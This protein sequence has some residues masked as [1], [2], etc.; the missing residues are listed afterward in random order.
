MKVLNIKSH[1][2]PSMGSCPDTCGQTDREVTKPVG[3]FCIIG[4]GV[5]GWFCQWLWIILVL[6]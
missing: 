2:N 4:H 5:F 1:R 6:R 3:D